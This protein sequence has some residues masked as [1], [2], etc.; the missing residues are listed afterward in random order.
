MKKIFLVF[1]LTTQA[2]LA[3]LVLYTDRPT[4]R[5]QP[6]ADQFTAATGEKVQIVEMA[7]PQIKARIEAEGDQSPA[8]LI[9]VKDLIYLNEMSQLKWF[10]PL[11]TEQIRSLLPH[12][13]V[14]SQNDWAVISYRARTVVY[15]INTVNPADI[16]DYADLAKPEWAGRIC[17]RSGTHPYNQA[18]VSSF[19]HNYGYEQTKTFL[20]SIIENL[21]TA[22]I[23]GDTAVLNA[24]ANGQCD[25]GIVNH[26]YLAPLVE[27]NPAFPVKAL[28]VNQNSTGTHVNGTG[29]GIYK[30]SKNAATAQKFVEF[31]LT[32]KIQLEFSAAHYDY[33]AKMNLI[34]SSLIRD[35]GTFKTDSVT[36]ENLG[37][38]F[39]QSLTLI[40]EIGYK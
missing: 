40:N 7:Y 34:P 35:W 1:L 38:Y 5:L 37:L 21:A 29:I 39:N 15:N 8:D 25:V 23:S 28:F 24:I 4:A 20:S 32:D 16:Q 11:Q 3:D 10:K 33:P 12:H 9:F 31:M 17:V 6:I 22:P 2:A 19:I 36:W 18:L 30:N 14:H 13:F 27:A 26:Y